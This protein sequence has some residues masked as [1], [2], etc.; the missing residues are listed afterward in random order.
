[1]S[2]TIPYFTSSH[3]PTQSY[4]TPPY[5]TTYNL[6]SLQYIY[7]SKVVFQV[8]LIAGRWYPHASVDDTMAAKYPQRRATRLKLPIWYVSPPSI[9]TVRPES[10]IV[11]QQSHS[12]RLWSARS[13]GPLL[14]TR[15]L[16]LNS[17]E[18]PTPA[19]TWMFCVVLFGDITHDCRFS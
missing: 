7:G 9:F 1:M 8:V 10:Q 12:T 19:R 15:W 16:L 11:Q 5:H 6:C 13:P 18:S 17:H 3:L 4:K 2:K 14:L